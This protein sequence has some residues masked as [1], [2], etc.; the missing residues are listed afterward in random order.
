MVLTT[1]PRVVNFLFRKNEIDENI[2]E[3]QL[4]I[5]RCSK[6]SEMSLWRYSEGLFV[7]ILRFRD[8]STTTRWKRFDRR[9]E[10]VY[11]PNFTQILGFEIEKNFFTLLCFRQRRC[12]DFRAE[13]YRLKEVQ[14]CRPGWLKHR[15]R[16]HI[17]NRQSWARHRLC[18]TLNHW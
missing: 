6:Q 8:V 7:N 9:I 11:M 3:T 17:K 10:L 5:T 18:T 13:T 1:Y 15:V 12:G 14:E 4:S 16:P 2:A